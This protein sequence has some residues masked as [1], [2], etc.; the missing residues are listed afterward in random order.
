[1]VR[2]DPVLKLCNTPLYSELYKAI[3]APA[4]NSWIQND[5]AQYS[6]LLYE[7][8][9]EMLC[10]KDQFFEN[11]NSHLPDEIR[12]ELLRLKL[13]VKREDNYLFKHDKIR[14]YL[15]AQ[16]FLNNWHSL[17]NKINNEEID[18]NWLPMLEFTVL[19]IKNTQNETN[20]E[21]EIKALLFTVLDKNYKIAE[22]LFGVIKQPHY[23]L[24]F[25]WEDEFKR[26]FGEIILSK[27]THNSKTESL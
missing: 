1:M 17:L 24:N 11:K 9:Y 20:F 25:L 15:A 19:E 4:A 8:A 7:R 16:H 14:A 22:K 26:K 10:S 18:T 5:H 6:G 23:S 3:L 12:D 27:D 2:D 21:N 13:I